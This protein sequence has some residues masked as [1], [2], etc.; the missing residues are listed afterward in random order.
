[1]TTDDD[2]DDDAS[3]H[4]FLRIYNREFFELPEI[5]LNKIHSLIYIETEIVQAVRTGLPEHLAMA[6]FLFDDDEILT[7]DQAYEELAT[8]ADPEDDLSTFLFFNLDLG[9]VS[10][11]AALKASGVLPYSSCAA[12]IIDARNHSASVPV[13]AYLGKDSKV[14]EIAKKSGLSI[15]ENSGVLPD[16]EIYAESFDAL[17]AFARAIAK[18]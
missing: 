1:M 6:R 8:R 3:E 5:D 7:E 4:S 11:V 9:V 14:N 18:G 17:I 16:T 13:I 2:D 10:A 12:N 15:V